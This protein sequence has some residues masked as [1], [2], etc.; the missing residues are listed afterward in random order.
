M[1]RIVLIGLIAATAGLAQDP[2]PSFE[3]ATVKLSNEPTMNSRSNGSKGQVLMSNQTLKRLIE[4]AYEVKPF[5]VV[6][7]GWMEDV[8][9]DVAAKFPEGT[10]NEDRPLML[11]TLLEDRFKLATHK[12]TKDLPGYVLVVAKSGFKLKPVEDSGGS[13]TSTNGGI[14][15]T[16][17]VKRTSIAFVADLLSRQ[18]G[19][20]VVDQTGIAGVYDFEF[21]WTNDDQA[22]AGGD[23]SVPSLFTAVEETMGLHL[24]AQKV[25]TEVVV[26]DHVERMPVENQL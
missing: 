8:R 25:P 4:R 26:V 12:E 9:F 21:K 16:M 15:R 22:P 14:I 11:R 17:T 6:G 2:R 10:K 13:D 24:K 20:M 1:R 18:L 19:Q 7:P 5:Q 3:A 23:A